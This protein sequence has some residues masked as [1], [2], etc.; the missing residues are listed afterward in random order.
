MI[1]FMLPVSKVNAAQVQVKTRTLGEIQNEVE[2]YLESIHSN[3]KVG[4]QE[5]L[6]YLSEQLMVG[7]DTQL[8]NRDDYEDICTYAAK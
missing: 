7:E 6:E 2:E 3:I 1:L 5:Y 4:T 8:A